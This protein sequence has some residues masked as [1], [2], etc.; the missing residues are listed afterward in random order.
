MVRVL[1]A[2]MLVAFVAFLAGLYYLVRLGEMLVGREAAADAALLLAA[3]PFAVFYSA[4]YTEALFLL[5]AAGACFHFLRREW[6]AASAWGLLAGLT[7]PN[8][9]LLAAPLAIL[10]WQQWRAGRQA[11]PGPAAAAGLLAHSRSPRCPGSA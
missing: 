1:W 3:Y 5:S 6:W 11:A 7:R 2:S 8:G 4:P 10:A 9:F